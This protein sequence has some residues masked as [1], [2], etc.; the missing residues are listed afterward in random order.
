MKSVYLVTAIVGIG[1]VLLSLLGDMGEG[2]GDI[3]TDAAWAGLFTSRALTFFLAA[4]GATG[5]L[6]N[7]QGL[8]ALPTAALAAGTGLAAMTIVHLAMRV[9]RRSDASTAPIG[10]ADLSGAI[11]R[12][13]IPISDG[14]RGQVACLVQGH[15]H[16]LTAESAD[17]GALLHPGQ[18]IVIVEARDGVARVVPAPL[19][20]LP[21]L[22]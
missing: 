5:L 12:V 9:L 13:T 8:S 3:E 1:L 2:D 4:F 20:D 11:G 14:Q 6:L 10:D 7:W 21:P 15:E 16:Y 18:T 22:T 17:V 19:P